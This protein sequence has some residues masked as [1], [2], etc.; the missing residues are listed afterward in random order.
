MRFEEKVKRRKRDLGY[1]V[2]VVRF[3]LGLILVCGAEYGVSSMISG[4]LKAKLS[5]DLVKSLGDDSW[6]IV[7]LKG[8]FMYLKNELEG[9]V[10]K[11]V[12]SCS[13]VDSVW[14][15]SQ[16]HLLNLRARYHYI[17]VSFYED[18]CMNEFPLMSLCQLSF[19][20]SLVPS[21]GFWGKLDEFSEYE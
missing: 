13:S 18:I 17:C 11:K 5:P 19:C 15:I 3:L 16:V 20:R 7:S 9:F 8:R 12:S 2:F 10:G 14:K 4:V 1:G 6:G 21:C